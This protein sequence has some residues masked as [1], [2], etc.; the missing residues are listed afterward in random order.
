MR[1]D[2]R[3]ADF[4]EFFRAHGPALRRTAFMMV[5][6][7]H[8]AE[9]LTQQ[10][11]AKLFSVWGRTRAETRVAYARKIVV[12][13]CL[14]HLRRRPRDT[15]IWELP[16]AAMSS[17]E[18]G[19]DLRAALAVLPARQRAIVALRYVEDLSISEVGRV[20][21]ISDGT[22]KS[23]SFRALETLRTRLPNLRVDVTAAQEP[24]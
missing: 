12:N 20:L 22:V 16:E 3:E 9:D 17:P 13:E 18:T 8:V 19:F 5:R 7:W 6:D 23:Q 14:S 4:T 10:G 21:G 11:L 15:P 2:Q 24:R 1:R